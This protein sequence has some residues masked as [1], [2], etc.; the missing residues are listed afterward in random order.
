MRLLNP[1]YLY[2]LQ[3]TVADHMNN[4]WIQDEVCA[5]QLGAKMGEINKKLR[6]TEVEISIHGEGTKIVL[7]KE[8]Q[9]SQERKFEVYF[10]YSIRSWD[11]KFLAWTIIHTA[12]EA[13]I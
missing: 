9:D 7:D 2:Q 12:R 10:M 11:F 3:M 13:V 1:E 4:Q 6:Q 5:L 8:N